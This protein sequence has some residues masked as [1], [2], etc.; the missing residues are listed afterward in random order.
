MNRKIYLMDL[1][2]SPNHILP[3]GA[4]VPVSNRR[5]FRDDWYRHLGGESEHTDRQLDRQA[6]RQEGR[7]IN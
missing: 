5:N 7:L 6:S 1:Y 3:N 4:S 2:P